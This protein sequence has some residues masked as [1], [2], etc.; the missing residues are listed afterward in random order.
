[1]WFQGKQDKEAGE[2]NEGWVD[3]QVTSVDNLVPNPLGTIWETIK[4]TSWLYHWELM[5][6]EDLSTNSQ[7]LLIEG[8]FKDMN[9][10]VHL[11]LCFQV[12]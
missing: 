5:E 7:P 12:G 4:H 3:E 6:L 11:A 1:M 10:L 9:F 8:H 2:A